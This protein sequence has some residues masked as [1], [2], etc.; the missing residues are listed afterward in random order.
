MK[1]TLLGGH[2][3]ILLSVGTLLWACGSSTVVSSGVGDEQSQVGLGADAHTE[4][5]ADSAAAADAAGSQLDIVNQEPVNPES[6]SHMPSEAGQDGVVEQSEPARTCSELQFRKDSERA[7]GVEACVVGDGVRDFR[8]THL[9][10]SC[11][12]IGLGARVG[13][14]FSAPLPPPCQDDTEC[15]AEGATCFEGMCYLPPVCEQQSQC[16]EGETCLCALWEPTPNAGGGS[17][18][19][20][21]NSCVPAQCE[22]ADDCGGR[23]C[24]VTADQCGRLSGIYCR[25]DQDECKFSADCGANERCSYVT[26]QALWQCVEAADCDE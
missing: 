20:A 17:G 23:E 18:H 6:A 19:H 26:Q 12:G 2:A 10:D 9:H 21:A 5:S 15:E 24:A 4:T 8:V 11:E 13:G 1:T 25:T 3:G 7:T 22:S 16:G 14:G